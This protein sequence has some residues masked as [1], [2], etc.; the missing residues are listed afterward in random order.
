[1][2]MPRDPVSERREA[3]LCASCVW[4]RTVE[5]SRGSRFFLCGMAK[6]DPTFPKYP[7]L[8][9]VDCRAFEVDPK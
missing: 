1:M 3:G 7:R 5:N 8:P 4:V 2:N 6:H 9:V